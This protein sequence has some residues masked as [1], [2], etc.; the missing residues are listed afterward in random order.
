M[1]GDQRKVRYAVMTILRWNDLTVNKKPLPARLTQEGGPTHF[2]PVFDT[3]VE[4]DE[5]NKYGYAV[6]EVEENQ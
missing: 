2:I 1:S 5:W 4:A 3:K 6:V